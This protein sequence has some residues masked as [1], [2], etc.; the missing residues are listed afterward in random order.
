MTSPAHLQ[1]WGCCDA[2][3]VHAYISAA[4]SSDSRHHVCWNGSD[5][6]VAP[7]LELVLV[8]VGDSADAA[9]GSRDLQ[10]LVGG[11]SPTPGPEVA[12]H[13]VWLASKCLWSV[14]V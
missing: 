5:I 7:A 6:S 3:C 11:L 1:I 9:F 13:Y 12:S 14:A 8:C 2:P 10:Q 4:P